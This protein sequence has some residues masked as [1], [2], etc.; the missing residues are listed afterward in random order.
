MQT[1][2]QLLRNEAADVIRIY[3]FE[4][5]H[6]ALMVIGA[7]TLAVAFGA[8]LLYL[9]TKDEPD[10]DDIPEF[11]T[12]ICPPGRVSPKC[13]LRYADSHKNWN[14]TSTLSIVEMRS[15]PTEREGA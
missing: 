2:L 3:D 7:F 11:V 10:P 13:P 12:C 15:V 14:H 1:R 6:T 9:A 8:A 5:W 4:W